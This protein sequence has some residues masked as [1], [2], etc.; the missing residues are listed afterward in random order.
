[1]DHLMNYSKTKIGLASQSP[2][3][4]QLMEAAGFDIHLITFSGRGAISTRT[5]HR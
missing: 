4:K 1:M 3:R 2:R 5:G